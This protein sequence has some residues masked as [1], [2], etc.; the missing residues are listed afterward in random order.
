[1]ETPGPPS[2]SKA[3]EG[4]LSVSI[5]WP[6][7]DPW[8][9]FG[10]SPKKQ[11]GAATLRIHHLQGTEIWGGGG[12]RPGHPD[13]WLC[14]PS[15]DTWNVTFLAGKEPELVKEV[16]KYQLAIAGLT[17][18]HST[19]YGT[20]VLE[21]GGTLSLSEVAQGEGC[22]ADVGI[23]TSPWLSGTVLEFSP[24]N[25]RIVSMRVKFIDVEALTLIC[26]YAPTES[27]GCVEE[28][29]SSGDSVLTWAAME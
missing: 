1:M 16:E 28:R 10:L 11:H 5:W 29:L 8:G 15:L 27:L 12:H 24:R 19:S 26:V 18:M 23:F 20:K 7:L 13:P 17:S 22:Q 25:K 14:R 4:R 2:W 21:T 9:P 6:G 3:W